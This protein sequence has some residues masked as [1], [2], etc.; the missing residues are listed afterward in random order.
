M[1]DDPIQRNID[2]LE[3]AVGRCLL[4][5]ANIEFH[6]STIFR[7]TVGT[8]VITADL[9]WSRIRSFD[10]KLQML[11]DILTYKLPNDE[12]KADWRRLKEYVTTLYKSRNRIAHSTLALKQGA[13]PRLIPFFVV[14]NASEHG[15]GAD[16]VAVITIEFIEAVPALIWLHDLSLGKLHQQSSEQTPDLIQ[17]LRNVDDQKR[18]EQRL[19]DKALRQYRDQKTDP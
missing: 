19:R 1:T 10:A 16:E 14:S 3:H 11:N 2:T 8:D 17:R 7:H 4:K 6:L 13:H 15:I 18:S 5:W 12:A 9:L